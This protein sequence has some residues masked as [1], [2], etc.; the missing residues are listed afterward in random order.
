MKYLFFIIFSVLSSCF[1]FAQSK[2]DLYIKKYSSLA[3]NEMIEFGVPASITLAQGILESGNGTS[4]LATQG[5]NH[6]GIKCHGWKGDEIYANDDQKNECFR[7]YKKAKDSYRDHS[8][9]LTK[10]ARYSYLFDLDITDYKGWARGLKDAGYATSPTYAEN[11]I[12][13][14]E[15]YNLNRFDSE[16]VS[17]KEKKIFVSHSY[18]FPF[19]YGVGLNYFEKDKYFVCVELGSSVVYSSSSIGV[20]KRLFDNLYGGVSIAGIYHGYTEDSS[21]NLSLG[22]N[23]KISYILVKNNK[24]ILINAGF[25]YVFEEI[26]NKKMVPTL[27]LTYLIN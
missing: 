25:L 4:R 13:L 26:R 18:G 10:H 2:T 19:L 8:Y 20:E 17:V 11:L 15:R 7:K 5:N 27:S 24:R 21:H 6:F 14:I 23:P 3:V 1:L 22:V 16:G 9:F 12:S